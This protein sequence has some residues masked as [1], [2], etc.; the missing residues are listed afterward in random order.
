MSAIGKT[1]RR[2]TALITVAAKET[3]RGKDH[4]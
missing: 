1:V 2:E 3:L 4:E